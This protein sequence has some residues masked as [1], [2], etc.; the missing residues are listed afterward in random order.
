[1]DMDRIRVR[2]TG[3]RQQSPRGEH[4]AVG[5]CNDLKSAFAM[6]RYRALRHRPACPGLVR[7]GIFWHFAFQWRSYAMTHD[8]YRSLDNQIGA[9]CRHS[10]RTG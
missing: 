10:S 4:L 7:A 2:A 9:R 3:T 6:R 8:E 1:M 5:R